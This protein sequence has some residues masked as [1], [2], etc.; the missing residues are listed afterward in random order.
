MAHRHGPPGARLVRGTSVNLSGRT[1]AR[2]VREHAPPG[3]APD[4][5]RAY[6]TS[7]LKAFPASTGVSGTV[8]EEYETPVW[9]CWRW[10]VWC[11]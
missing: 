8:R 5:A 9:C 10:Q 3:L 4:V 7:T 6:G 1:V 11:C 2:G